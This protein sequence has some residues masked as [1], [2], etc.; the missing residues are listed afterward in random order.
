MKILIN[1]LII[2]LTASCSTICKVEKELYLSHSCPK[3][4]HGPCFLCDDKDYSKPLFLGKDPRAMRNFGY[5]QN[6]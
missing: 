4:G 3:P 1:S 6:R 5:R 2:L